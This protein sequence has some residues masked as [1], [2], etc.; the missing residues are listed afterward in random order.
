MHYTDGKFYIGVRTSEKLPEED[1]DYVGSSKYTPNDKILKKEILGIFDTREAAITNEMH[2]QIL[3]DVVKN[4]LYYNRAIQ[5][6]IGFDTSGLQLPKSEEHAKKIGDALRGRKRPEEVGKKVSASKKGRKGK[7]RTEESKKKMSDIM[8]GRPSPLKNRKYSVE[9]KQRLYANRLKYPEK[10]LW[11]HKD[12]N[13]QEY[14]SCQEM[15]IMDGFPNAIRGYV[16]VIDG[17]N[18]SYHRWMLSTEIQD[19]SNDIV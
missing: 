15:G 11:I 19:N 12:T 18:K 9:E 4:N 16:S 7:P 14:K 10:Y 1:T 13:N 5:T 2:H 8:K 3:N 6:S 17:V